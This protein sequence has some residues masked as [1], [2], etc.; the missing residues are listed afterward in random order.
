MS[1]DYG[2]GFGYKADHDLLAQ[3]IEAHIRKK[4]EN[5]L[6]DDWLDGPYPFSDT[7]MNTGWLRAMEYLRKKAGLDK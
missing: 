2:K 6:N 5:L 3:L 1:V 7:M 4:L